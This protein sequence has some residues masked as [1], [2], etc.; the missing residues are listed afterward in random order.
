MDL[1]Q[2]DQR[3]PDGTPGRQDRGELHPKGRDF[4][5][6]PKPGYKPFEYPHPLLRPDAA[7]R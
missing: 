1:G 3:R 2:P 7:V 5:V 4:F 6:E